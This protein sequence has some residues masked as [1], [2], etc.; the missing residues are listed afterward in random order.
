[1]AKLHWDN[2]TKEER[3]TYMRLQTD[4]GYRTY[5]NLLAEGVY[6]CGGCGNYT[7]GGL[8]TSCYTTWD[9]LYKKLKEV[10]CQKE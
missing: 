7:N 2:L 9:I 10:S 6:E 4:G 8:C 1:M 5:S 3:T